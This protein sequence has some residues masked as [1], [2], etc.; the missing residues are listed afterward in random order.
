MSVIVFIFNMAD[1]HSQVRYNDV[2]RDDIEFAKEQVKQRE[3]VKAE[4]LESDRLQA[5]K[6]EDAAQIQKAAILQ[7][8]YK[9]WI[10]LG[11]AEENF[12]IVVRLD[13][14]R[15]VDYKIDAVMV[16]SDRG[17][18]YLQFSRTDEKFFDWRGESRRPYWG[19]P[20]QSQRDL[21]VAF[22]ELRA[23]S[24]D[25]DLEKAIEAE[26]KEWKDVSP[27]IAYSA[28][29]EATGS[30][31]ERLALQNLMKEKGVEPLNVSSTASLKAIL[32]LKEK[33]KLIGDMQKKLDQAICE[34]EDSKCRIE[35]LEAQSKA[36]QEQLAA[37]LRSLNEKMS[38][39]NC[40]APFPK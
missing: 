29:L 7:R 4:R 34:I 11:D 38:E 5:Q 39:P 28:V 36:L 31:A 30:K 20:E 9:V 15:S 26:D 19:A 8:D 13:R 6:K 40:P 14:L 22:S 25:E 23:I 21:F 2:S 35:E 12:R 16:P 3:A 32:D 24:S 37:I 1:A 10:A 18:R 17:P 27:A 33:E